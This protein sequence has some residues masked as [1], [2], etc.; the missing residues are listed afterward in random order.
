MTA[1]QKKIKLI[2]GSTIHITDYK[3]KG[4]PP[5]SLKLYCCVGILPYLRLKKGKKIPAQRICD[6]LHV[7][8]Y[9]IFIL[10]FLIV[11]LY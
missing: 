6:K 4:V 1:N 7:S 9:Y 10:H 3:L 11:H 8:E 5:V 2:R